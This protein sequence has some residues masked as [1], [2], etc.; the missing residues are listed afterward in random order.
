MVYPRVV[1]EMG[2]LAQFSSPF[3]QE[4]TEI[5]QKKISK[6][7]EYAREYKRE[8]QFIRGINKK[9]G[10]FSKIIDDCEPSSLWELFYSNNSKASILMNNFN[11]ILECQKF[12]KIQNIRELDFKLSVVEKII[13][14]RLNLFYLCRN[15]YED[16]NFQDFFESYIIFVNNVNIKN[17]GDF[18]DDIYNKDDDDFNGIYIRVDSFSEVNFRELNII[19]DSDSDSDSD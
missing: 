14:L 6:I 16:E 2:S 10:E 9:C 15:L 11:Y 1:M 12:G 13:D 4:M 7:P 3:K 19:S 5:N 18:E 17:E 8:W